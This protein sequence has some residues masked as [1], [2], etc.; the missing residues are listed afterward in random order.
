MLRTGQSGDQFDITKGGRT[1]DGQVVD[2]GKQTAFGDIPDV[3]PKVVDQKV[4][5][6]LDSPVISGYLNTLGTVV[7]E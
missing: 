6:I 3:D 1:V 2:P 4:K 7:G 5:E